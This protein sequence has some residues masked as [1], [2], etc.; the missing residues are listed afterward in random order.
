MTKSTN[1]DSLW[2]CVDPL[3]VQ[4]AAALIA[5]YDPNTVNY[6]EDRASVQ[7]E[8]GLTDGNASR[9]VQTALTALAN[10]IKAR[11]LKAKIRRTAWQRG[12]DEQ[13]EEGEC[14]AEHVSIPPGD[15]DE[16]WGSIEPLPLKYHNAIIY[17]VNPDWKET[18]ISR[19][20]LIAWLEKLGLRAA[21]F[22]P[23]MTGDP[24]Y[25][26][27]NNPRYAPKL[28]AAVRA[29]Q[30]VR[31]SAGKTPKQALM[32]WLND[33]AKEFGLTDAQGKPNG[34]GIEEVAKVANWQPGGGAP[35]TP[36][37]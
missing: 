18:T 7:N 27:R 21:F 6:I 37:E 16:A 14:F 12:Y 11:T 19:V 32:K 30:S 8:H 29:W 9:A 3:S 15:L 22:F 20:D 24:D 23:D 35:K 10:A 13:P 4:Q 28:A 36:G 34:I 26:D 33:H 1:I 2:K 31:D 5:G 17:R 25:L